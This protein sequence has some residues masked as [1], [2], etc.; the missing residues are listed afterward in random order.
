MIKRDRSLTEIIIDPARVL[1]HHILFRE[2]E[3]VVVEVIDQVFLNEMLKKEENY[4]L[5]FWVSTLAGGQ[6]TIDFLRILRVLKRMTDFI[7]V[8]E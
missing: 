4:A 3:E 7:S 8:F 1:L 6:V 5:K 2:F